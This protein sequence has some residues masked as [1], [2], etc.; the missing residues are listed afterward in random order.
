MPL[1]PCGALKAASQSVRGLKLNQSV[2]NFL[3]SSRR[4]R[5]RKEVRVKKNLRS[6]RGTCCSSEAEWCYSLP[7][8][9]ISNLGQLRE[10]FVQRFA[11]NHRINK[12]VNYLFSILQRERETLCAWYERFFGVIVE[13]LEVTVCETIFA[14]QRGCTQGDFKKELIV[15]PT[16]DL[17]DLFAKTKRYMTLEESL[18]V[19]RRVCTAREKSKRFPLGIKDVKGNVQSSSRL[20][21]PI[22]H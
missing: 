8:G 11:G 9:S 4:T 2:R 19:E 14:F 16:Q 20:S 7:I 15:H 13:V 6:A 3:R 17:S 5:R 22:G 10:L 1:V 18:A 21:L 12:D